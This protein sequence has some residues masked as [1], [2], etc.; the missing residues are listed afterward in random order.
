[1]VRLTL[2][3]FLPM[4]SKNH[5]FLDPFSCKTTPRNSIPSYKPIQCTLE[6]SLVSRLWLSL[7][8]LLMLWMN[9]LLLD[10]TSDSIKETDSIAETRSA[11]MLNEVKWIDYY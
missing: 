6:G 1:M 7:F 11:G 5:L 9:C 4:E 8:I 2:S 10:V 3:Y